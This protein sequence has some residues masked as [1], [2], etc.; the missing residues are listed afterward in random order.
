VFQ[1]A[2]NGS[3]RVINVD[4]NAAYPVAIRELKAE[5]TL[6]KRTRLRQYRY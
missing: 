2:G 1:S 4:Q 5:G 3:P 6:S